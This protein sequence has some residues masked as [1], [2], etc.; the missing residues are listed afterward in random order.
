MRGYKSETGGAA[1]LLTSH[2]P[3]DNKPI[4]ELTGNPV[5]EK[6]NK[7]NVPLPLRGTTFASTLLE[8]DTNKV[9]LIGAGAAKTMDE[10][11]KGYSILNTPKVERTT[12]DA[13]LKATEVIIRGKIVP[14]LDES[15]IPELKP[16]SATVEANG[17]IGG[18]LEGSPYSVAALDAASVPE[19]IGEEFAQTIATP[20]IQKPEELIKGAA[21]TLAAPV[22]QL[23]NT[24]TA[25][26]NTMSATAISSEATGSATANVQQQ[27]QQTID[28]GGSAAQSAAAAAQNAALESFQN[29]LPKLGAAFLEQALN[30]EFGA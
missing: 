19:K 3:I 24:V 7:F 6:G 17:G 10:A 2:R 4:A 14:E 8:G 28:T 18:G 29:P 22:Q 25:S 16:L 27:P 21:E 13:E 15:T 26:S 1:A 5:D 30:I 20:S 23:S 11:G 9:P 12:D